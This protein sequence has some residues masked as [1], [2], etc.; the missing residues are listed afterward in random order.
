MSETILSHENF[1]VCSNVTHESLRK[2][3]S[4]NSCGFSTIQ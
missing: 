3:T 2:S 1:L 4:T